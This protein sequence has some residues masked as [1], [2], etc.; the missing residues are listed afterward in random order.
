MRPFFIS[1][2]IISGV[3]LNKKSPPDFFAAGKITR[4]ANGMATRTTP[5]TKAPISMPRSR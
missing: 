2:S 1:T 5:E 4:Q 3:K